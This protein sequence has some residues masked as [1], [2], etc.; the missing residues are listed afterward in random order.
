MAFSTNLR[1]LTPIMRSMIVS[2]P[3]ACL[4]RSTNCAAFSSAVMAPKLNG[5]MSQSL[6]RN[7]IRLLGSD[8]R[9]TMSREHDDKPLSFSQI[10]DQEIQEETAELNRNLTSD[11]FPGFSV[12][13]DDADVKLTKQVGDSTVVVRFTV[14]SSLSEWKTEPTNEQPD[15]QQQQEGYNYS[16]L[17]MPEFQVQIIRDGKTLEMNCYF[18]EMEHDEESGDSYPTE[19]LFHIDEI[20]MYKGEPQETEFSVSTEYFREE[21]QD[22]LLQYL[23]EHGIDDEFAKNLVSFSTNYEKKLYIGLMQRLKEFVS[24]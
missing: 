11:Q 3:K 12:E 13:T 17:S 5:L 1:L 24:K 18:E 8:P 15:P 20:V 16:L 19:P 4:L 14:S 9:H 10:L 23:A 6:Q 22:G 7:Q 21:L 2:G